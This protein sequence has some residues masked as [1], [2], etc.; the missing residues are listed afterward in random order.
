MCR[1]PVRDSVRAVLSLFV[2]AALAGHTFAF[3]LWQQHV[4]DGADAILKEPL[5]VRSENQKFSIPGT[6]SRTV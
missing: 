6:P 2:T 1:I 3:A 5:N 4:C